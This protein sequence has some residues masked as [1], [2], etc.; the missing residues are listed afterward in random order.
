MGRRKR[1]IFG[2]K[3]S[4]ENDSKQQKEVKKKQQKKSSAKTSLDKSNSGRNRRA[5]SV[6]SAVVDKAKIKSEN[7]RS[8]RKIKK[9]DVVRQMLQR[10]PKEASKVKKNKKANNNNNNDSYDFS[11][12][13][14]LNN[15]PV[16][17]IF[18]RDP[19]EVVML[20]KQ[21]EYASKKL[22][23]RQMQGII[24]KENAEHSGYDS[25]SDLEENFAK[26]YEP[27]PLEIQMATWRS[28]SKN[29]IIRTVRSKKMQKDFE[30]LSRSEILARIEKMQKS[31]KY[32]S[33][34]FGVNHLIKEN[35][36]EV[37][38]PQQRIR[39]V[40][41]QVHRE[42]VDDEEEE[43]IEKTDVETETGDDEGGSV[44][45]AFTATAPE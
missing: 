15:R 27:I 41:A 28:M 29:D 16:E 22:F 24:A 18:E 38:P 2:G 6:P 35:E 11:V 12:S 31:A 37:A 3:F 33:E 21:R 5:E 26:A 43:M 42:Q 34:K 4:E 8:L 45:T 32:L 10:F 39:K 7:N 36:G 19:V 20:K 13:S 40:S 23:I 44:M 14:H 9:R 25:W 1:S 30:Y 17:A